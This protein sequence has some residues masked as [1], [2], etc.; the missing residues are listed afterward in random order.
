MAT[1]LTR[2]ALIGHYRLKKRLGEGGNA[3][4]WQAQSVGETTEDVA[5]KILRQPSDRERVARFS[6]EVKAMM[7]LQDVPGVL[8]ILTYHIPD[9]PTELD[10]PY[11]V[12]PIAVPLRRQLGPHPSLVAVVQALVDIG[13][14]LDQVH[15]RRYAHRDIKPENLLWYDDQWCVGDFGLVTQPEMT[16]ITPPGRKVGSV[17]YLAPELLLRSSEIDDDRPAD[18]YSLPKTLF[19]LLTGLPYPI[20]GEHRAGHPN[21]SLQVILVTNDN[22]VLMLDR[23]IEQCTRHNPSLRPSMRDTVIELTAWLEGPRSSPTLADLSSYAKLFAAQQATSLLTEQRQQEVKLLGEQAFRPI[24][25]EMNRQ[26]TALRTTFPAERV[27]IISPHRAIGGL[28]LHVYFSGRAP[29]YDF[30]EVMRSWAGIDGQIWWGEC[31]GVAIFEGPPNH[32]TRRLYSACYGFV[33]DPGD[34]LNFKTGHLIIESRAGGENRTIW[35]RGE[36]LSLGS[37]QQQRVITDLLDELW[38]RLPSA[39]SAFMGH[40]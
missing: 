34:C 21:T 23:L 37:A 35:D 17:H 5:I 13:T 31:I 1:R 12:T 36:T 22:Q 16:M 27:T 11:F 9:F 19:V 2:G 38:S 4:V 25:A 39:L 24:K 32:E 26:L 30:A 8:P 6:H 28:G 10:P 7:A 33:T 15:E 3:L 14:V 18:V 29:S 20:P 40:Q